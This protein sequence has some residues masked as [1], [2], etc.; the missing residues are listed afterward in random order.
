MK[1]KTLILSLVSLFSLGIL[2]SCGTDEKAAKKPAEKED[3]KELTLSFGVMPAVDSLPVYIAEKEGF[4]KDEGLNLDLQSFKSPKD[5]D[6]ALSSG[7]LDGANTDLI[8]VSTYLEGGMDFQIVSQSIGV[9]SVLTS[10]EEVKSLA[11][12]K[13]KKVGIAKNQAPYYFLDEALKTGNLTVADIVY[14]EVPQIPVRIELASNK[15]IDATVVPEPFRTIGLANGLTELGN[16]NELAIDSTVFGFTTESLTDNK[17]AVE[18]FYRGYNKGVDFINDK[19][20]DEYYDVM[21]EKIGFTDE[22]KGRVT[23]PTYTHAEQIK[24]D[25]LTNAL[26]WSKSQ[27]IYSKELA[28]DDILSSFL[29]K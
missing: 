15:K 22:I 6:A 16:S 17:E 7:N 10:N 28:E 2:A 25:Q 11:D 29:S 3:K 14:E 23:L 5:R 27:G 21:K 12:L 20:L 26:E 9:F 8:A 13:D 4:F 18:A 1:K 24:K 19:S